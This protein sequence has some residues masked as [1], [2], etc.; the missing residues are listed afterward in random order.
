LL[1]LIGPESRALFHTL[2][3][4]QQWLSKP[5]EQWK[6]EPDVCTANDFV[7]TGK[8]VNDTAERGVKLMTDFATCITTDPIQR[9][10]LLQ[11]VEQH[12]QLYPDCLKSTLNA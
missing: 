3:I 6:L 11:A 9:A 12:R 2:K 1:D 5:V 8:V 10:A 7:R 4:G